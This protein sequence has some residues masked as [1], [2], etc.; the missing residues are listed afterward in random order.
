MSQ[1]ST[2]QVAVGVSSIF[3]AATA[4]MQNKWKCAVC[5]VMN[6]EEAVG[7]VACGVKNPKAVTGAASTAAFGSSGSGSGGEVGT[8]FTFGTSPASASAAPAIVDGFTFGSPVESV[9]VST[10]PSPG[11]FTFGTGPASVSTA[12]PTQFTFGSTTT[13]PAAAP[14]LSEPPPPDYVKMGVEAFDSFDLLTALKCF[15]IADN[16]SAKALFN[17]ASILH[18]IGIYVFQILL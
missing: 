12:A 13:E 15:S 3:L 6:A 11:G 17:M 18:M 10:A 8:K 7:C 9:G 1:K 5:S 14:T 4:G 16:T 2:S